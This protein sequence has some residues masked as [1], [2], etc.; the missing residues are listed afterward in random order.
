MALFEELYELA[1]ELDVT[2]YICEVLNDSSHAFEAAGEYDLAISSIQEIISSEQESGLAETNFII[3]SRNYAA[4][5]NGSKALEWIN[6]GFEYLGQ[7]VSPLML[8]QKA[9][10]LALVNRLDEAEQALEDAMPPPLAE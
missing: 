5:G 4:L 3:L 2:Y 10:A 7:F 9:W 1:Q 6:R 8:L